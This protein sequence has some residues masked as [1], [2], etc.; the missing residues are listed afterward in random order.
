MKDFA[1]MIEGE[2]SA[3]SA[4]MQVPNWANQ[5]TTSIPWIRREA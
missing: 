3:T 1:E 4:E 5:A 2:K